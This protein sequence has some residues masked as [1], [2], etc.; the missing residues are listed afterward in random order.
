MNPADLR[1][2]RARALARIDELQDRLVT[3]TLRRASRWPN[4]AEFVNAL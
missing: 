3:P 4:L 1:A 2:R